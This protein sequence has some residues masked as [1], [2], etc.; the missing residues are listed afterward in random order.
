MAR[1]KVSVEEQLYNVQEQIYEH[2]FAINRG[3]FFLILQIFCN[4][5]EKCLE[6]AHCFLRGMFSFERS[7]ARLKEQTFISLLL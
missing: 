1:K 7:L 3:H 2:T 6:K 5:R 4:A